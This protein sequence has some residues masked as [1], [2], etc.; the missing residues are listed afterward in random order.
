MHPFNSYA[1]IVNAFSIAA[2][3]GTYLL[4][5]YVITNYIINFAPVWSMMRH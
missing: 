5:I 3:S 4:L 2:S 1:H